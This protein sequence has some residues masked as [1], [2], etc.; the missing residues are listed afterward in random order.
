M[1]RLN[2][3]ER[4]YDIVLFGAT[5]F[6]GTLT[7]AYLAAHAPEGLRWAIAGR[8][9]ERLHALRERLSGDTSV[10][11]LRADASDPA[12]L[13]ELARCTRVLA[14]TVGPYVLHGEGLV[15]AC[16][17][18]GT[19]YLDLC[20]E[21]EFV[22]LVYVRHDTRARETGAR[23]VH[24]CGFDSVPHD[25][26]VYFTVRQLPEGVPLTVDGFVRADGALSGGTL[27]SALNQ[28]A[29]PLRMRAAARDRA[30]HEP[31]TPGRRASTPAGAPRFAGEVGAWVLP[32]PTVD[33]QIVRRS[34]RMLE[35][36]GPDFRYRHYAAVRH[37]PVAVG[38][39]AA[40]GAAVAAA[41]L[42]PV[43]RW[44][45]GRLRPGQGPSAER[46]ARSWFSVRFVGEGGGR[47][48]LT[49]VAGGDPGYGETAKMFAESALSLALD[50]LPPTAGQVTTAVAMG[51]ALI[52]RLRRAGLTFRTAAAM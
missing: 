23:L 14:T 24:A 8:S 37:L 32:L 36:Y 35:R 48:V 42:P 4:P 33:P 31:R 3:T 25:L 46:R 16:A 26:G 30:R 19:D 5:G 15:A 18:S 34:A 39:V 9:E 21:P 40:V 12:S 49:E 41:Q 10:G 28:F 20:G 17:D 11:V 45:S 44:L 6:V 22:D 43:R 7:A 29:R 1:S 27:A 13:R 51:D 50:D 52:A 2:K 38:G 47:R